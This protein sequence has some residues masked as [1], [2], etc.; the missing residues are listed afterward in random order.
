MRSLRLSACPGRRQFEQGPISRA[1]E[2]S[3]EPGA[4]GRELELAAIDAREDRGPQQDLAAGVGLTRAPGGEGFLA[5]LEAAL[6]RLELLEFGL[7][8]RDPLIEFGHGR[9]LFLDGVGQF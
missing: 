9:W 3:V 4:N 8:A 6:A 2:G 7:E 1:G 5:R